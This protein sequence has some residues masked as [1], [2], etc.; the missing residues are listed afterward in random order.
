M[1]SSCSS[2]RSILYDQ[3]EYEQQFFTPDRVRISN[4]PF[5]SQ[6]LQ[7]V[8]HSAETALLEV[9]MVSDSGLISDLHAA[10]DAA[11][12]NVLL[13]RF[14]HTVGIKSLNHF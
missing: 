7:R 3:R 13:Q 4:L 6:S 10:F 9:L 14:E 1:N 12:H 2:Q 8:D 11:E 5:I